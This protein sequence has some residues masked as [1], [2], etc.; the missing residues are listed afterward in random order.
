MRRTDAIIIGAGQ[1]G[2]AMSHCLG[3]RGT[4]HI[5]LERGQVAERWRSER[6]DS[7]RLL[8]PNWMNR[9]P[10]W[11]YQGAEPDGFLTAAEFVALLE[12]YASA[13]SAP[14]ITG[15]TVQSVRRTPGGYLV[16][17]DRG[18]WHA[19]CVVIATGHCDVP[20]VPDMSERLP[21]SIRQLTPTAY[22]NPSELTAGDVLVVGAS[23]SG[24]QLAEEIQR[25]GR[26]VTLS[27]SRHT[28]LPRLY[29]GRDIMC[30][31]DRYDILDDDAA[32]A[33]ELEA[34]R[35]LP[36]MQLIGRPERTNI[37]LGVLRGIGVRLVGRT[38]GIEG[39]TLSLKN[40]LSEAVAGSHARMQRLL[41]R[42]DI[43]G[44][45]V[46]AP[47][48]SWPAAFAVDSAPATLDLAATRIKTVIW[49]TGFVRNYRWLRMPVFDASGEIIHT[50]GVTPSPGLY[51]TGLR[52]LRRRDA[53]FI[54]AVA[55]DA[56]ELSGKIHDF[57]HA[58]PR[59]A[60]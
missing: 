54:A 14:V 22:R 2:L 20:F 29:R 60:A 56:A 10:G 21:S 16:E 44:D 25:S 23:A 47:T 39:N 45:A 5:V 26:Q 34:V 31:L 49:A 13:S 6:W 27:V 3:R 11:S 28:R 53:S 37:D 42:I 40:N 50:G 36:S 41:R 18:T 35:W 24:V 19:R 9:F 1:A 58:A 4:D 59:F 17:S 48:E 52:F 38:S 33:A 55:G 43:F 32:T 15:A 46:G 51:V 30:W 7:L 57:L 12:Q 8:T